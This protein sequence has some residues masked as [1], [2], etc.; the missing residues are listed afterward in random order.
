MMLLLFLL[1]VVDMFFQIFNDSVGRKIPPKIPQTMGS[2]VCGAL[3][4]AMGTVTGGFS[5]L[6]VHHL[7]DLALVQPGS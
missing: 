6:R 2:A 5:V 1:D 4:P 3:L 7:L